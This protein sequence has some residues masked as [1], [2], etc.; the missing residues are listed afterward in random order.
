MFSRA[1]YK[2][3]REY[4]RD[5]VEYLINNIIN[6]DFPRSL[7]RYRLAFEK[8]D[9]Q[10]KGPTRA[11]FMSIMW[12][13]D[14]RNALCARP[15]IGIKV[16]DEDMPREEHP[17]CGAWPEVRTHVASFS[18]RLFG[19]PYLLDTLEP[20]GNVP[21]TDREGRILPQANRRIY[22]RR[23]MKEEDIARRGEMSAEKKAKNASR[24]LEEMDEGEMWVLWRQFER[25]MTQARGHFVL[26][27]REEEV[28]N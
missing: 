1:A 27:K 13:R 8:L 17:L 20:L 7:E 21:E 12:V 10:T 23:H 14:F 16:V 4:F 18:A 22:P 19:E 9:G 3:V 15:T 26:R 6:P 28:G 25:V 24:V 11:Q 2:E 5:V